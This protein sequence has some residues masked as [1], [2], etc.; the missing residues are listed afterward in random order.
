MT[1]STIEEIDTI[2][3][4]SIPID[5]LKEMLENINKDIEKLQKDKQIILSEIERRG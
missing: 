2:N 3:V 5:N 4:E 1:K